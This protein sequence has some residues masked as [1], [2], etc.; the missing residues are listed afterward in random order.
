MLNWRINS[1]FVQ[2]QQLHLIASH[3]ACLQGG[4]HVSLSLIFRLQSASHSQPRL[5]YRSGLRI[6]MS[7]ACWWEG[8][9]SLS[10]TNRLWSAAVKWKVS[11][12]QERH[13][14]VSVGGWMCCLCP[15]W[16][17]VLH[18]CVHLRM[19]LQLV[20]MWREVKW[21]EGDF[22]LNIGLFQKVVV[23]LPLWRGVVVVRVLKQAADKIWYFHIRRD[24]ECNL[25]SFRYLL[26]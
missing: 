20:T 14:Y 12:R 10:K 6:L 9:V 24:W 26:V 23:V 22:L 2:V 3:Y 8:G 19:F 16:V 7:G 1:L 18:E 5:R 4:S 15:H 17:Q 21:G 11:R 13:V 25:K